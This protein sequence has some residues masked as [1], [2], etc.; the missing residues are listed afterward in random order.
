[1]IKYLIMVLLLSGHLASTTD[2]DVEAQ[3]RTI[4]LNSPM[5]EIQEFEESLLEEIPVCSSNS[6][7]SFMYYTSITS[8]SS[9]QYQF[10]RNEMSIDESGL[11]R[12]TKD[13]RFIGVALGSYFGEIGSRFTFTLSTGEELHLI[14]IEAKADKHVVNGCEHRNDKS[15]IEFV[16]DRSAATYYSQG[17]YHGNFNRVPMFSGEIVRIQKWR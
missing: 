5:M 15:V 12:Y 13:P 2:T 7:K 17:I 3:Y 4:V 14:K 16:I 8:K 6:F 11:L 9:K 10:I 1:M